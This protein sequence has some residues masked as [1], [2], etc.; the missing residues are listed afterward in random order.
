MLRT[1]WVH[2]NVIVAFFVLAYPRVAL[3]ILDP[4]GNLAHKV[5]RLWG[6]W[7]LAAAGVRVKVKGKENLLKDRPQVV[8]SN[9]TSYFDVFCLLAHLPIQFRWL[10][11][12][13][14]F[15]IPVFG[16]VM[17][18]GGYLPVDR[19]NPRRAHRTMM[20]AAERIRKGASIVIFPEGTRSPDGKLQE[21]KTGGVSLA[22]MAQVP[23]VPVAILGTHEI[24]P[25]GSLRVRPRAVEI[26]IGDPI[27]IPTEGM[28]RRERERLVVEAR[29]RI[30]SLLEG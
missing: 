12:A 3:A 16:K 20:E 4:S 14:L 5:A 7:I 10:A 28:T 18:Y 24:M 29:R 21:F 9:H 25:K 27:P 6:R 2:L 19:S 11:K 1:L 23:V 8:F 30:L 22:L 17:E 26:R 15:K 13:E